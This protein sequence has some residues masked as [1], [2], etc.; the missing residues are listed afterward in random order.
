LIL[1]PLKQLL[2]QWIERLN[3]FLNVSIDEIGQIGGEKR[4]P[5]VIIDVATIQSLSRK[6]VV[7]IESKMTDLCAGQITCFVAPKALSI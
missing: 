5:T 6:G 4:K 2:D 1:V 3:N 7:A